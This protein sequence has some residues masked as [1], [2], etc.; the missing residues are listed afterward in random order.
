MNPQISYQAAMA[1]IDDLH[2]EA[3]NNALVT[4]AG[5]GRRH[6]RSRRLRLRK[7]SLRLQARER[8]A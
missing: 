3:A 2:R 6:A 8:L 5:D 1:R 7:P 4:L